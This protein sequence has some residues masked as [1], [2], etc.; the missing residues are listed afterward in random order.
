MNKKAFSPFLKII[1]LWVY[2]LFYLI[3]FVTVLPTLWWK[4]VSRGKKEHIRRRLFPKIRYPVPGA[5]PLVWVHAVSV[6][7]VYAVAPV[8]KALLRAKPMFRI[9]VSTVTQTGHE[10]A[11]KA[12]PEAE[13][14]VYLPFDFRFSIRRALQ[15]GTPAFVIFSEGDLWP[16]F[17]YEVKSRGAGV[18]VVNGKISDR[19]ASCFQRV[20]IIGKWLYSFVDV[21]CL[22]NQGFYDRYK[23]LGVDPSVLHVT[24]STKADITFPLLSSE[25]KQALR[26]DLGLQGKDR[27]IV[28]GSTH[29]PE[30]AKLTEALLPVLHA[31]PDVKIV[32]VPRHPERYSEVYHLTK[33]KDALTTLYSTYDGLSQWNIMVIDKLGILTKLYQLAEIAVV[34]GSFTDRVGGHNILEPAAVEVPVFVGPH[35]QSQPAL[36]QSAQAA[37]AITQVSYDTIG[38]EV[39]RLLTDEKI[40]KKAASEALHWS[41]ELRGATERTVKIVIDEMEKKL[42]N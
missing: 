18:A 38:A 16:M 21:F 14:F 7:E 29:S 4:R 36:F 39:K 33:D 6:G 41:D 2:R 20:G 25:E 13:T 12:I 42:N 11:R 27:L 24:G 15:I 8:V 28:L 34:C 30:E 3:A 17:L 26:R 10:A 31:F 40:R 32:I 37:G 1:L 19:T 22:Q 9:I 35:M 5:G 23:E